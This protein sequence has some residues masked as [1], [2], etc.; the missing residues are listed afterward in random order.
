MKQ[1]LIIASITTFTSCVQPHL[2]LMNEHFI[3]N[4][5]QIRGD[6]IDRVRATK[7]QSSYIQYTGSDVAIYEV[8]GYKYNG[9][10]GVVIGIG[11]KEIKGVHGNF[12]L[13]DYDMVQINLTADECKKIVDRYSSLLQD[14][15]AQT[16]PAT[17]EIAYSDLR[18]NND[19]F[20]SYSLKSTSMSNI[21]LWIKGHKM[22][23]PTHTFISA[24]EK[25]L[26]Q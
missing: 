17:N 2:V 7:L 13:Y 10:K 22:I 15:R 3:K 4:T 14:L 9:K 25:Y 19:L 26:K 11:M 8:T 18:I 6:S 21:A 24:L 16:K 20:I 5:I 1:L 12:L 23:A